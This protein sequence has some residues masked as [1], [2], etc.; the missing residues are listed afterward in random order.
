MIFMPRPWGKIVF[1]LASIAL[2]IGAY[3][4]LIQPGFHLLS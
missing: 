2:L 4:Y 3:E 1:P